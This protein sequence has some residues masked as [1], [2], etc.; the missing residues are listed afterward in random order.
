[1]QCEFQHKIVTEQKTKCRESKVQ[2]N[3]FIC[4]GPVI[5]YGSVDGGIPLEDFRNNYD[6][7]C[8]EMGFDS[9]IGSIQTQIERISLPQGW[10]FGCAGY[11]APTW[12][13]CDWGDG[14]WYNQRLNYQGSGPRITQV[15]C[16]L[17][18]NNPPTCVSGNNC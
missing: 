4:D 11:D 1:M 13:W 15:K 7:W 14:D 9:H 6:E 18:N 10:L 12:H 5:S 3:V 8:K 16:T 17:K 2:G